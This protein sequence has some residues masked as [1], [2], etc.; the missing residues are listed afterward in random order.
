M[1]SEKDNLSKLLKKDTK[2][3]LSLFEKNLLPNKKIKN[4]DIMTKG[5]EIEKK[6][7]LINNQGLEES[8]LRHSDKS[9]LQKTDSKM[10]LNKTKKENQ[11]VKKDVLY[12]PRIRIKRAPEKK[13]SLNRVSSSNNNS[14]SLSL[15][16]SNSIKPI[17]NN[18]FIFTLQKTTNNKN[19]A[20]SVYNSSKSQEEDYTE[21]DIDL[22][23]VNYDK[24]IDIFFFA[25][26]YFEYLYHDEEEKYY[27][28]SDV[29]RNLFEKNVQRNII[30]E[31]FNTKVPSPFFPIFMKLIE[32]NEK[33]TNDETEKED[34]DNDS[35]SYEEKEEDEILFPEEK[36][37]IEK[38]NNEMK[39]KNYSEE[40]Y[41]SFF[42]DKMKE[43][44]SF[45]VSLPNNQNSNL[46]VNMAPSPN[47]NLNQT[48]MYMRQKTKIK[49]GESKVPQMIVLQNP[50]INEIS[51][52]IELQGEIIQHNRA[53]TLKT[54]KR[55]IIIKGPNVGLYR[56]KEIDNPQL[57]R[58]LGHFDIR[59]VK[60][61]DDNEKNLNK[62]QS[63]NKS[64]EIKSSELNSKANKN[65]P[66]TSVNIDNEND[67]S[68]S[69]KNETK[70]Q[71]DDLIEVKKMYYNGKDITDSTMFTSDPI[72]NFSNN[73][74]LHFFTQIKRYYN[75]LTLNIDN[76]SYNVLKFLSSPETTSLEVVSDHN[77]HLIEY[78]HWHNKL[79]SL[80]IK[81]SLTHK[82][83]LAMKSRN[84]NC[85]LTSLTISKDNVVSEYEKDLKEIFKNKKSITIQN[86]HFID[87]EYKDDIKDCLL[88]HI[89]SFYEFTTEELVRHSRGKL[90]DVRTTSI[91]ILNLSIKNSPSNDSYYRSSDEVIDLK[92]IYSV[93]IYMLYKVLKFN[94]GTVPE[95]FNCLDISE[96]TV[97]NVSYLVKIITKFKIIKNLILSG[98]VVENGG[99]IIEAKNFLSNIKL[100]DFNFDKEDSDEY[101]NDDIYLKYERE[102]TDIGTKN[103]ST[104]LGFDFSLGIF[105]I[106]EKIEVFDT[107]IKEDISQEI[108]NL[109]KN[110]K[111]FR[112][113]HYSR[114]EKGS[115]SAQTSHISN[116]QLPKLM[117]NIMDKVEKDKK[118]YNCENIFLFDIK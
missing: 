92:N 91:P 66:P 16:N 54:S 61:E 52:G 41:H 8:S 68:K 15:T 55:G 79:S 5:E 83:L 107:D 117:V 96:T 106:L 57:R 93:L 3:A 86:I 37:R 103:E 74:F 99:K 64:Y 81:S 12:L 42:V 100:D 59:D 63:E 25:N 108:Y 98:T 89:N 40:D 11:T 10:E 94:K 34:D 113:F 22:I 9:S 95:V 62:E 82:V 19:E 24:Q 114:Q 110:L 60:I 23:H 78:I 48:N 76:A 84:W 44:P 27:D 51:F 13:D 26:R 39:N 35:G 6:L 17:Y 111:F 88:E 45:Y 77:T 47:Q 56:L 115:N 43:M 104:V 4:Y 38:I 87:I 112:E 109:F 18:T 7:S 30:E 72:I 105:P 36:K 20:D 33:E 31:W 118:N 49:D 1:D 67:S 71:T 58:E 14:I 28:N 90:I 46:N 50:K 29:L 102:Y 97:K 73:T 2:K 32:H 101:S 70:M 53:N 80:T 75:E 21:D 116:S 85:N 69:S 65:S